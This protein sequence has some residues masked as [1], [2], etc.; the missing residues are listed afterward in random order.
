VFQPEHF[1][2]ISVPM[3]VRDSES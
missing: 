1:H 2:A 3:P